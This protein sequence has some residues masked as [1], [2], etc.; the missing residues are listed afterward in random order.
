MEDSCL[1]R[2]RA[3]AQQSCWADTHANKILAVGLSF[4]ETGPN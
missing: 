3:E 2:Y 1:A 4:Y